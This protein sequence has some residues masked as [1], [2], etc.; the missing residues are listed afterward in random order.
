ML[1]IGQQNHKV[2]ATQLTCGGFLSMEFSALLH[3]PICIGGGKGV[4]PPHFKSPS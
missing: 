4:K 3:V 2:N 1:Y